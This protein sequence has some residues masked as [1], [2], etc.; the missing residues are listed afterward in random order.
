V[1]DPLACVTLIACPA[2]V[3]VPDR[4][5]LVVFEA[6][7]NVALPLP[8]PPPLASVI[9]DTPL[10]ALHAQLPPVVTL[11]GR[12]AEGHESATSVGET[13]NVQTTPA[14]VTEKVCPAIVAVPVRLV[15][16][17]LAAML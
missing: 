15:V 14:C 16:F 4:R 13:L 9:Q 2:T 10:D 12:L 6:T 5:P 8:G 7:L 11:I 3:S 17:G 1:H